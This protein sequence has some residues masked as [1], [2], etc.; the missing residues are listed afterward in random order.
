MN[1]SSHALHI[2]YI[3]ILVEVPCAAVGSKKKG[4]PGTYTRAVYPL[5]LDA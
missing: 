2:V 1:V 3:P 5:L 4:V